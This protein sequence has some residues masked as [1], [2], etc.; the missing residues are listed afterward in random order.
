METTIKLF[1]WVVIIFFV[2]YLVVASFVFSDVSAPF[3]TEEMGRFGD[4][5][6]VINGLAMVFI[7]LTLMHEMKKSRIENSRYRTQLQI[8]DIEHSIDKISLKFDEYNKEIGKFQLLHE[9]VLNYIIF[10]NFKTAPSNHNIGNGGLVLPI[11]NTNKI[12][13]SEQ[14][15][16]VELKF[17]AFEMYLQFTR[18]RNT[19][20]FESIIIEIEATVQTTLQSIVSENAINTSN[21]S[22]E[23]ID[24]SISQISDGLRRLK[25]SIDSEKNKES[26]QYEEKLKKLKEEV[27]GQ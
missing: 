11:T 8:K 3:N 5:F 9:E 19:K 20:C 7:A 25:E 13:S 27:K 10:N 1:T 22:K 15:S 17:R 24:T 16:H 6:G 18:M 14:L 4:S 12:L 21:T 23:T 26:K 2:A